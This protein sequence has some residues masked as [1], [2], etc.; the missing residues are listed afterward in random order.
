MAVI[1][2]LNEGVAVKRFAIDKPS[3]SIGRSPDNDIFIDDVVV[4][5]KHAIIEVEENPDHKGTK[6][7]YITDLGSTNCTYV[8]GEKIKR[9]QLQ[10]N[11][12]VR[13]G[14][15]DFKFVTEDDD[16]QDKTVRICKSWIPGVYYTK[17]E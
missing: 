8:N 5:K 17:E 11:D 7:Y 13:I 9:I 2:Q 1:I 14:L 3:L 6:T 16:I 15:N 4:S 12:S 10:H